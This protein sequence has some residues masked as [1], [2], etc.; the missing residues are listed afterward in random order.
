MSSS[1]QRAC[2]DCGTPMADNSPA[3]TC[4]KCLMEACFE[5]KSVFGAPEAAG[6]FVFSLAAPG[7]VF[8][9][10]EL[11]EEIARGGMGVVF[12]ARQRS[13]GR[14]V[15]LKMMLPGWLNSRETVRRF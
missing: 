12:K 1:H 3:S 2:I 11:Q 15:A 4:A 10:Y 8:G 5:E 9:D 14:I 7:E 6:P 13:L